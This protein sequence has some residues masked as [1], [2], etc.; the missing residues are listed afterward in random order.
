LRGSDLRGIEPAHV[1]LSGA[2]ITIDQTLVIAEALGFD[3]RL[4]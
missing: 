1:K 4:D 3:V 2:I